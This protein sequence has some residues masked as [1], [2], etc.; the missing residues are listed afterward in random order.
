MKK[1]YDVL[2]VNP[3]SSKDEISSAYKR[4]AKRAHPDRGGSEEEFRKIQTAYDVLYN[5]ETPP[6]DNTAVRNDPVQQNQTTSGQPD[7]SQIFSTQVFLKDIEEIMDIT[8]EQVFT[9]VR[10]M[11]K[12]ERTTNCV[13]CKEACLNCKGLGT[14]IEILPVPEKAFFC[15]VVNSPCPALCIQGFKWSSCCPSCSGKGVHIETEEVEIYLPKGVETGYEMTFNDWGEHEPISNKHGKYI[16]KVNV[17]EHEHFV[18]KSGLDLVFV[19]TISLLDS[20]VGTVIDVPHV[21][22][23]LQV[24]TSPMGIICPSNLYLLHERGL[25]DEKENKGNLIVSF[26]IEYPKK[27]ELSETEKEAVR[28]LFEDIS[29]L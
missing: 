21:G 28:K 19:K 13:A 7:M 27:T 3:E 23:H 29:L 4:L 9:G 25:Q 15:Q 18:R 11:K 17:L 2:G 5:G 8:L 10:Y 24:D 16:I 12:L 14:V 6:E 1:Y 22:G 26:S 20:F